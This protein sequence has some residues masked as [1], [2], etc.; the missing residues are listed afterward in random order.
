MNALATRFGTTALKRALLLGIVGALLMSFMV[1]QAVTSTDLGTSTVKLATETF[2]DDA[3]VTV[4]AVGVGLV[5]ANAA[6]AGDS[7]PGVEIVDTL[8]AVN[9]ALTKNNY[10]Y[11]FDVQ[12]SGVTTL[13]SAEN[14]KIQVYGD[15][16]STT[17]LLATLYTQ[18]VTVDDGTVEGVQVT[19]DVGIT[20]HDTYDIVVSRQ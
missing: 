10:F 4:T 13:Q 18:Q 12:E 7:A 2:S 11:R 17:T 9:N 8:P 1:A 16:G 5:S 14:L 6:A 15:D 3:D 19:V 20:V